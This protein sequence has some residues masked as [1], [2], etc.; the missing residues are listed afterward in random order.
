M[1][2]ELI[3]F[4]YVLLLSFDYIL[5]LNLSVPAE[6]VA[7]TIYRSERKPPNRQSAEG[8]GAYSKEAVISHQ[9]IPCVTRREGEASVVYRL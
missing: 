7:L 6:R 9:R 3:F 8:R 4:L 1:W 5:E 2:S